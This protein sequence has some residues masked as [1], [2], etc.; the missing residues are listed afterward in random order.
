M[1]AKKQ[2][3]AAQNIVQQQSQ[4]QQSMHQQHATVVAQPL[5]NQMMHGI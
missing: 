3:I 2:A 5:Q 4:Q 1:P